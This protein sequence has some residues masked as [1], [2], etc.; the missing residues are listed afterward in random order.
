MTE[1]EV[2][3]ALDNLGLASSVSPGTVAPSSSD[4]GKVYWM[5]PQGNVDKGTTIFVKTYAPIPQPTQPAAMTTSDPGPYLPSQSV[6]VNWPSYTGCPTGSTLSAYLITIENGTI[7]S[8]TNPVPPGTTSASIKVAAAP[9]TT[10]VS[11]TA[12][13]GGTPSPAAPA[14]TLTVP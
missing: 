14:L 6:T 13:C 11:Y 3:A 10:K 9:G 5:D 4:V 1:S 8:G 7:P 2:R 12:S